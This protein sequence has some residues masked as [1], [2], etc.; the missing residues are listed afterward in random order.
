MHPV[1]K[2]RAL[3]LAAPP[4]RH[5]VNVAV[6]YFAQ[7]RELRGLDEERVEVPDGTTLLA[8]YERL[9]AAG[10]QGRLPV[11][12]ARNACTA[13]ADEVVEDGDEIVFIP[14]IGGG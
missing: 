13:R 4:G 5:K 11:S 14:P 7:L 1:R 10:P 2:I 6:R 3:A 8:L 9:F 12:Y